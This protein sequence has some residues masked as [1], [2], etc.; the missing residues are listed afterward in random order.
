[1][2]S[3]LPFCFK[4]IVIAACLFFSVQMKAQSPDTDPGAYMTAI[5]NAQMDMNKAYLAYMSAV[6]HNGRAKKV[7]KIRLQT[8]QSIENCKYKISDLPFF[9]GDNSFRK[10]NMDYVDLCYKVFNDDYAHI[11]N[12]EDIIEQ[13]FDEMQLYILLQEKTTEKLEEASNKVEQAQKDF[14]IKYNVKVIDVKNEVSENMEIA[15][16]VNHYRNQLYLI[17]YKCNWQDGQITDA[18]NAK[19]ISGL[20]EARNALENYS[21]EGLLALDSLSSFQNDHSLAQS[22]RQTLQFYQKLATKDMPMIT[23]FYLKEENFNK[24]KKATELKGQANLTKQDI[25][26]YNKAVNDYN[27]A[28][29]SY[30]QINTSV[31]A[32]RKQVLDNWNNAD[33]Q[34]MDAHIP[35]VKS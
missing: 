27:A 26:T 23:D 20:E 33:R 18:I 19:K 14:A 10:S 21:N 24:L 32:S 35:H 4:C 25:D 29:N 7:E 1:M 13:S 28:V 9:R 16:K 11:V 22:C 34:F 17:F 6:A 5:S 30:N 2:K 3:Y 31:N 8:L 12:M 15:G